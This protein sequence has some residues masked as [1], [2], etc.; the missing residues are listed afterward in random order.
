MR[1]AVIA[2]VVVLGFAVP[3]SAET[4]FFVVSDTVGN[5]SVV[6]GGY[7]AGL[8]PIGNKDG[9]ASAEDADKGLAEVRDNAETCKGVVE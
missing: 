1:R 4:K 9:Y 7:S 6:E 5:C 3:A 8:S 2:S